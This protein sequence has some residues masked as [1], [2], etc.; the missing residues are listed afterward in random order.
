MKQN[1]QNFLNLINDSQKILLI[2]H[3]RIDWDALGSLMALY[4]ILE[5]Q[6]KTVKATS[7]EIVPE[8][9]S[10]LWDINLIEPNLD[11]QNFNPDLIVILDCWSIDQVWD[12][13]TQ[14][15]DTIKQKKVVTIDHHVTNEWFWNVNI[16]D[17][18]SSSACELLFETIEELNWIKYIDKNI[19]TLLLT[20]IITDTNIYY[21]TNTT[22][23]TLK[24]ASKLFELWADFRSPIFQFFRKKEFNKSKLWWEI[25]KDL[26]T[27][28]DKKIVWAVVKEEYFSKTNTQKSDISWLINEFLANI[29]WVEISFLL[30][31]LDSWEIKA[32]F[33]SSW[34][35]ISKLCSNFWWW[36]HKQAA[37]FVSNKDIKIIEKEILE[38]LDSNF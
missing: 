16:I 19:A 33:R 31:P 37:W 5:K 21:N 1:I 7:D 10:F 30:Y 12:I 9:F 4:K 15:I 11:I 17:D 34:K 2:S 26:K 32:S 18:K 23:K 35:D 8:K 24:V 29:D 28:K 36:W 38:S 14:N 6:W 3:T 25:L 20:W 13:S 27:T 22:S